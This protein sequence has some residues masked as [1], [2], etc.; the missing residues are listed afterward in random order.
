MHHVFRSLDQG[1]TWQKI[2]PDLTYNNPDQQ[3]DISYATISYEI[4]NEDGFRGIEI[5]F[6]VYFNFGSVAIVKNVICENIRGIRP[7]KFYYK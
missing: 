7:F 2:S 4:I 3:G 6:S 1:E 5:P